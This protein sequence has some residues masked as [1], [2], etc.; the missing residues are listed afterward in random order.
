M[1]KLLHALGDG[2]KTSFLPSCRFLGVPPS[3]DEDKSPRPK[4]INDET[5]QIS[6][7]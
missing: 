6:T 2:A 4:Q 3:C 7:T 5:L 1:D